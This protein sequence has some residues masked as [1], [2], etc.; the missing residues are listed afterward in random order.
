MYPSIILVKGFYENKHNHIT[1][2]VYI[3]DHWF[4]HAGSTCHLLWQ[5]FKKMLLSD[6]SSSLFTL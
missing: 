1:E 4:A 5:W 2:D 3:G 6:I